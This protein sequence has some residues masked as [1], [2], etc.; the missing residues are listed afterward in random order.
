MGRW[1]EI[2]AFQSALCSFKRHPFGQIV[3]QNRYYP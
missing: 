2:G 1:E 3:R